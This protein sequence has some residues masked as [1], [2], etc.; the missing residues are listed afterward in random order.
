MA[1]PIKSGGKAAKEML[2]FVD[3]N[4]SKIVDILSADLNFRQRYSLR[5]RVLKYLAY[6]DRRRDK[7]PMVH[8]CFRDVIEN[9]VNV[10]E[11]F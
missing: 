4:L 5:L 1:R 7:D 11:T 10:Y 3:M 9:Y 6:G 2:D 8:E